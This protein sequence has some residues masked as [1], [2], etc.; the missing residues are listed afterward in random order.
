MTL[1]NITVLGAAIF[2][3]LMAGLFY[4]YSCS[5]T[6]GLG[7]LP[8]EQYI[9]AMQSINRSIQNPV[10]FISFFGALILPPIATYLNYSQKASASFWL[11]LTATILYLAGS[12]GVTALGNIPLNNALESFNLSAA[13]KE[14]ISIQRLN[15]ETAWNTLNIIRTIS[16]ILSF[17]LILF[18]C[19]NYFGEKISSVG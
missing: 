14:A 11:L 15:F 9:A 3:G 7:K 4:S 6:I 8:D 17:I 1:S 13:S 2:T 19:L 5:V 16:A 10:F 18:A 12:F